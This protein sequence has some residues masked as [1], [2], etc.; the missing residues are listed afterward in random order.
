MI[1][2]VIGYFW[3]NLSQEN[4]RRF[5]ILSSVLLF[6][7]GSY[8]MLRIVKDTI[9]F[10]IAFPETLGWLP[11]QGGLYQPLA[12]TISPLFLIPCILI[13]SKLVDL[14]ERHKL[15]YIIGGFYMMVFF[16]L[17]VALF[18]R[19]VGGDEALGRT[20]LAAV[21]WISYLG[22]ESFGSIMVPLF[23]SFAI[24]VTDSNT[25]KEGFPLVITGAQIGAIA[26]SALNIFPEHFGGAG[27]LLGLACFFVVCVMLLIRYYTKISAAT[28]PRVEA[29]SAAS[30]KDDNPGFFAG[31]QMILTRPYIAGVLVCS[32]VYE[33][34]N[35]IVD[36]QMKRLVHHHPS[37][38][39]EAGF[40]KFMGI[41]GLATN[42]L[43]FLMALLGT[44]YIMRR[45]GL[46]FC[47]LF[48][49]VTLAI[50]LVALYSYYSLGHPGDSMMLWA[51]FGAM[52]I[53]KGLSYAVNNPAKDMMYIPTSKSAKF[54][55]KGWTDMFGG[56]MAK[57]G[58]AQMTNMLKH[59]M[60]TLI[61]YGTLL[62]LGI[63]GAW[64][65]VAIY[66]GKK[67]EQLLKDGQIVD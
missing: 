15:F 18:V 22:I 33:V 38:P 51:T 53:M 39:G 10:T 27:H 1:Y 9:F 50:A 46:R 20:A 40:Q 21:G 60:T 12:K 30:K 16:G 26:G 55:A 23:W 56:R 42:S 4:L 35:T 59:N 43:A 7:I 37:F 29:S 36:Y 19:Q 62:G 24:S 63:I 8:W 54:K 14:F 47:L 57:S 5:T 45:Y 32:T 13:Y 65:I 52:M 48:Y 58:G 66:V 61:T 67:N 64:I 49:P 41:F 44:S 3:P 34:I 28:A 17:S 31:L 2:S 25:A 6:I 11:E